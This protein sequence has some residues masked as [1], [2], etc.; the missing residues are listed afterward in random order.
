MKTKRKTNEKAEKRKLYNDPNIELYLV[1]TELGSIIP[2]QPVQSASKAFCQLLVKLVKAKLIFKKQ[3]KKRKYIT[4][5]CLILFIHKARFS[6]PVLE[7]E[8]KLS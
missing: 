3:Q 6:T 4:T 7:Q 5:K 2:I 8:I 1:Q